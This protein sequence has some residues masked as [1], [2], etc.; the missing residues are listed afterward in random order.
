LDIVP[1]LVTLDSRTCTAESVVTTVRNLEETGKKQ[2]RDFVKY[3]FQ[4]H[5][6]SIHIH[7][8]E[9]LSTV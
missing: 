2:Y 3:V 9:F 5:S 4:E 6:H 7:Q 1:D 8:E